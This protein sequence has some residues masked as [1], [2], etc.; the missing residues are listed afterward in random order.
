MKRA[1]L[2]VGVV[3]VAAGVI[4]TVVV[5]SAGREDAPSVRPASTVPLRTPPSLVPM[6]GGPATAGPR[7]G[8][9]DTALVA[10]APACRERRCR[11]LARAG[12]FGPDGAVAGLVAWDAT[13]PESNYQ[14]VVVAADGRPIWSSPRPSVGHVNGYERFTRDGRDRLYLAVAA[15]GQGQV[16]TVLEWVDGRVDDRGTFTAPKLAGDTVA[17]VEDRTGDGRAE[18]ITQSTRGLLAADM[19]ELVESVYTLT[20]RGYVLTQ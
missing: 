9:A 5:L 14:V 12:G 4:T 18:V 1:L 2:P 3:V 20:P 11:L 15:D 16:M 13:R 10:A 19:G 6:P 8:P 7:S 17:F